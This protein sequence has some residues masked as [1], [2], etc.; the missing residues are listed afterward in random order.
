MNPELDMG[1]R[2]RQMTR[3]EILHVDHELQFMAWAV[4]TNATTHYNRLSLGIV[5]DCYNKEMIEAFCGRIKTES[6]TE[7]N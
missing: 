3:C 5:N 4:T 6:L 1:A 7:E 2:N